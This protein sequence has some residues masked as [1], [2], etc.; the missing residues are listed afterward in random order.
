MSDLVPRKN[1]PS[2]IGR[3]MSVLD[4]SVDM[5]LTAYDGIMN[6][7]LEVKQ[8]NVALGSARTLQG[9]VRI[10][11]QSRLAAGKLAMQEAKLVESKAA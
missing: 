3:E 11:I 6:G 10:S 5:A 7:A 4:R 8:A 9:A 1:V 2:S